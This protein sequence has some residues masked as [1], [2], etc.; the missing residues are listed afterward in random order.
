M[1]S[2]ALVVDCLV[3]DEVAVTEDAVGV[4]VELAV[5]VSVVSGGVAAVD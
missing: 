2:S 3:N 5:I 4:E 1:V